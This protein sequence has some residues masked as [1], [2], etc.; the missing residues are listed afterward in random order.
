MRF[1]TG[2][3]DSRASLGRSTARRLISAAMRNARVLHE[4]MIGRLTPARGGMPK[5]R[6]GMGGVLSR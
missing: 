5:P 1:S 2:V 6:P 3:H 4:Q